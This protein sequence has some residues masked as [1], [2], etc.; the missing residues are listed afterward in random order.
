MS[1][2]CFLCFRGLL[3]KERK[4]MAPALMTFA[5]E[6]DAN[7]FGLYTWKQFE[8]I[9]PDTCASKSSPCNNTYTCAICKL[10]KE[11]ELYS[12]MGDQAHGTAQLDHMLNA[13]LDANRKYHWVTSTTYETLQALS[14]LFAEQSISAQVREGLSN[15]GEV[16]VRKSHWRLI[17]TAPASYHRHQVAAKVEGIKHLYYIV[18][19]D[20]CFHG[21]DIITF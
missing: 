9:L 3:S 7:R 13:L 21:R 5:T 8:N 18:T 16:V 10:N 15:W 20:A 14:D 6:E 12:P 17:C 1:G 11:E 2:S 19:K 4:P